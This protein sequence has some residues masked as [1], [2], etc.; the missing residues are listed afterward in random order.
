VM[1]C[2]STIKGKATWFWLRC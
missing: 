1:C 2:K